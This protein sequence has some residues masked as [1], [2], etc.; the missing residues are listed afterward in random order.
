MKVRE[1]ME[2]LKKLLPAHYNVVIRTEGDGGGA[3]VDGAVI[4][5]VKR[6]SIRDPWQGPHDVDPPIPE[7]AEPHV[8][9]TLADR[10][11]GANS[12]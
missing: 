9:L 6:D 10:A 12:V 5:K 7:G 11:D 3:D 1:L 2:L 8:V 4:L